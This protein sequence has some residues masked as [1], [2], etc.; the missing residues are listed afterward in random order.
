MKRRF[1]I[2][3]AALA[4]L[5]SLAI[6]MG[7]WG[8][9]SADVTL[10]SGTFNNNV[11]TW[12]CADGNI[13]IQQLKGS[14]QT[15]PSGS[16]ISAPRVYKQNI[17]S[18]VGTNGYTITNIGIKYDGSYY[19]ITKYAGT[20][21]TNN[22]VENNASALNPTWSTSAA[23][24]HTIATVSSDG[25]SEIYI[26]NGHSSDNGSTQLRITK[27]TITYK[28]SGSVTATTVTINTSGL[29]NTDVYT[30][31]TAGS[32][33][34]TVKEN[35]NNTVIS[36]ATVTWSSSDTDVATI[37]NNGTVTLVAAGTTTI[38]ASYEGES[39]VYGSS[40]ATYELTVTS[41]EPYVQP[42]TIE[43]I[44]NYEFWG[45]TGQFSGSTYSELDG[46]QDNVSLH[47][48]RGNGSTYANLSAMRFYKD[49]ELTFTAPEGYEIVSIVITFTT[50]KDDLSFSP[51]GYSLSGTTGTWTGSS[52][53]VTM[54]RPSNADSY[55]QISKFTITLGL[56]STNPSITAA[57]VDLTYDA[58]SGEIEYTITNP[59]TNGILSV[60]ENV[61]WISN[62]VVNTSEN[63]VTFNTAANEATT[64]RE[65]VI[66]LTYTY[67]NDETV[68]K[69]VNITQAAAPLIYTTIP[70]LF[71]AATS[72]ATNV[73]VTF[74][75]WVVS[76]V[77][78][79]NVFVTDNNG[80]GFIIYKSNHGF[81]VND[82]LSGTVMGT[83]LKLY[84]GSAEFTNLTNTTDGLSVSDDGTI[85]VITDKTIADL[86]GVNTGAVITLN[87]LTYD[88]TNLSDGTN[89][90][91]PYTTLYNGTFVNG[92][93]YNV[94]GV[95]Q[96]FNSTKEILPRS[97]ADIEEVVVTT[98][99][100]TV[101]PDE[102][103]VDAEAHDGTLELTYENLDITGMSDFDI[104]FFDENDNAIAGPNWMEVLVAE[105]DPSIGDG[106]VV[107][108]D[109]YE[110]DDEEAH[111]A[112]F[113]V[114]AYDDD[115]NEVYSNL[116][117][118]NQA[119][120][121]APVTGDKYV[122]VT[123]T[124]DLTSG[125]YLIVY[126]EGALA[127]DGSLETLD[128][129]GNTIPVTIANNEIAVSNTTAA[130]EFTINTTDGTIKSAS[131]Y[132]IGQTTDANGLKAS[133]TEAYTNTISIDDD[134]NAVVVAS[135]GAYLRYNATSGQERFRYF[136]SSTY[137]AQ[138]AIQLYK[139]VV[140]PTPET[141]TKRIAG[142]DNEDYDNPDA[143]GW[144][145]IA[146]PIGQVDPD[147]VANMIAEPAANY[148]L[149]IFDQT[150]ESEW[151]NYKAHT[152]G[153][154][155]EPGKGYL[156]ANKNTVDLEFT[157]TAYDEEGTFP[158]VYS[159]DNPDAFMHGWNLVGNPFAEEAMVSRPYY[160]LDDETFEYT[161]V[162]AD[163]SI[164][165]ME[166]IF[167]HVT[168]AEYNANQYVTFT[169]VSK[170]QGGS[171]GSS[172]T[173]NLN[174]GGKLLDRAIVG[175][176]QGHTLP[177][178]Q[179]NRNHTK[180]YIPQDGQD[181]AIVRGEEMG[182]MPVN[183]KAENDGTYSLS[184]SSRNAEF[185]YLHLIDNM[186]GADVDLL[187]T[188]SYSFE[189]RTTDY[190]SRFKL[191]F[192]TGNNS[193][194][195]NF[196]FFSNGSFVINNEGNAT[197]QVIDVTGRIISSESVNGCTNVNV[198]AAPGVYML[199]LVNGENVR[200]QKVVVK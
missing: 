34:A 87:N 175:F 179:F 122:K 101:T 47:W 8:Q 65:G 28:V 35:I 162:Q 50:A 81:V 76:G 42:T 124:A 108:Y 198:N 106:Y 164:E 84:S 68:T 12:T 80:N 93:T 156:Y 62:A 49:N 148:D 191:V 152:E 183:F 128:A 48:T 99:S 102:V 43:I 147:D 83:P 37:N 116:V 151:Q 19:G 187:Q 27:L 161:A 57:D 105:Q 32:L 145:L 77:S 121:V 158:L 10:S 94:T 96:Q 143:S 171:K 14:G 154:V 113:K 178:F 85:T 66:T 44:P 118:I 141:F 125:Q 112:Y 56:P 172:L 4:L 45:K 130:S 9:T 197:L 134:G 182:E 133:E 98:P 170:H 64:A 132:Y 189:A 181:Y 142:W 54:S 146:S 17:L 163:Q 100:I 114:W 173:L 120:P 61:D 86:G 157:G 127:F 91:K 119:A 89:T 70:D 18:F 150:K 135:G 24:T 200:V 193:K 88:G 74:G 25:L 55:A 90:I 140:E 169:P 11:I 63:K 22:N 38:T 153:F 29:T 126:E 95:Y 51:E 72:T 190:E 82:K 177:K 52:A 40:S 75:N 167:V 59:A 160:T 36:G 16:Y 176:G 7:V 195:D 79:S 131:G 186:T 109:I 97:A 180:V 31:T 110:N 3:T 166:G 78:G 13:T 192:A 20:E 194:D 71:N 155:L 58:T 144:Y 26:Q 21:I 165:A 123:S 33:S 174:K 129:S 139:K 1:T 92:K 5:V 184:F 23:G 137:T 39:G 104:Q 107:S 46:S 73:N 136:K 15:N 199:R 115:L 111:I 60:S 138:K 188:Q 69:D 41:S 159:E 185:A 2:L 67:G 196:A 117:T 53:I 168:E 6:P 149:F 103:N 30:S